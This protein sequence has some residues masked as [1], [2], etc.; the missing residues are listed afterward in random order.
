MSQPEQ[1]PRFFLDR[2]LGRKAVP[3][4]LRADGWDVITLAEHYGIP[5]DEQVADTDW[6]E[7]AAKHGWPILMKDKRIRH[8][9]AEITAVTEHKARCFVITRGDLPSADMANA[10]S[11]TRPP[12]SRQPQTPVRTSTRYRE[13]GSPAS[14][15]SRPHRASGRPSGR[16]CRRY[17]QKLPVA[18]AELVVRSDGPNRSY[19]ACILAGAAGAGA[20]G[21]LRMAVERKLRRVTAQPAEDPADPLVILRDLPEPE[22]EEFLRQYHRAV[23]AA[24]EPGRLPAVAAPSPRVEPDRDRRRRQPGYYEELA[25]ARAGTAMTVP[26]TDAI[27]DWTERVAAARDRRRPTG[28]N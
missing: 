1:P 15:H 10:S 9:Q 26:V 21:W 17:R 22:R 27:P 25:A 23:D 11:P 20:A 5:A 16:V 4:A 12:S 14:I 28:P 13:T 2:S 7:E 6:I 24:H 8:R 3:E 19:S 18:A